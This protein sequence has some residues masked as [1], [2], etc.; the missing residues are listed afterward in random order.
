MERGGGTAS[1][2][3]S[4]NTHMHSSLYGCGLWHPTIITTVT[5]KSMITETITNIMVMKKFEILREYVIQKHE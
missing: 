2:W 1:Q 4:Q 3:S 5:S